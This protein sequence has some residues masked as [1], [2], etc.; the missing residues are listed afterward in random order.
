[1][2]EVTLPT[3]IAP[4]SPRDRVMIDDDPSLVGTVTSFQFRPCSGVYQSTIEVSYVH[5]G[6]VLTAWIEADR[7][8]LRR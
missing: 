1:M 2:T 8:T 4:F 6:A 7:L 3:F 5:N